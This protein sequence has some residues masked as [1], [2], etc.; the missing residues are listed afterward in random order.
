M[1]TSLKAKVTAKEAKSRL[2]KSIVTLCEGVTLTKFTEALGYTGGDV[3]S[4]RKTL[5]D[6]GIKTVEFNKKQYIAK[7]DAVALLDAIVG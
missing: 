6:N 5:A 4:L 1:K 2:A 3:R 7:K